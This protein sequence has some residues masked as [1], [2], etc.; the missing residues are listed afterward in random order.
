MDS[1]FRRNDG[2]AGLCIKIWYN[3]NTSEGGFSRLS[4]KICPKWRRVLYFGFMKKTFL[5]KGLVIFLGLFIATQAQA[6]IR[7]NLPEVGWVD[8]T[9]VNPFV[10]INSTALTHQYG[11]FTEYTVN[12]KTYP[13][14]DWSQLFATYGKNEGEW[15]TLAGKF[16]VSVQV[17]PKKIVVEKFGTNASSF[18]SVPL[19]RKTWENNC[20]ALKLGADTIPKASSMTMELD[21]T[22]NADNTYSTTGIKYNG[23]KINYSDGF[24]GTSEGLTYYN[25]NDTAHTY[26]K[27]NVYIFTI[28]AFENKM[29]FIPKTAGNNSMGNFDIPKGYPIDSN[30]YSS[31]IQ[32]VVTPS[33]GGDVARMNE[34]KVD[35]GD[36]RLRLG[37]GLPPYLGFTETDKRS[38]GDHYVSANQTTKGKYT[39]AGQRIFGMFLNGI[40]GDNE[41]FGLIYRVENGMKVFKK[42]SDIN[43]NPA[44]CLPQNLPPKEI[45]DF[46]GANSVTQKAGYSYQS[47]GANLLWAYDDASQDNLDN[48]LPVWFFDR[49]LGDS[50]SDLGD[51]SSG[52]DLALSIGGPVV[53]QD[54]SFQVTK[55]WAQEQGFY[56]Y[57]H[58]FIKKSAGNY[59]VDQQALPKY[60]KDRV[61]KLT[62]SNKATKK[63]KDYI[64]WPLNIE[65]E[66]KTAN[67]THGLW[68]DTSHINLMWDAFQEINNYQGPNDMN[69]GAAF[70]A[71]NSWTN[72]AANQIANAATL[73]ANNIAPPSY[74]Y[75]IQTH[76]ATALSRRVGL[77]YASA[78][79][80][81]TRLVFQIY[82][83]P[84]SAAKYCYGLGSP[85][86][87]PPTYNNWPSLI[88]SVLAQGEAGLAAA[89][90]AKRFSGN[91]VSV[92]IS[93]TAVSFDVDANISSYTAAAANQIKNDKG[94]LV[95]GLVAGGGNAVMQVKVP[96]LS[97]AGTACSFM[98]MYGGAESN[99]SFE[100]ILTPLATQLHVPRPTALIKDNQGRIF[101]QNLEVA[102]GD[103]TFLLA[104]PY[105]DPTWE[106]LKASPKNPG[107]VGVLKRALTMNGWTAAVGTDQIGF[108][109]A[110]PAEYAYRIGGIPQHYQ[111]VDASSYDNGSAGWIFYEIV[112]NGTSTGVKV[113]ALKDNSGNRFEAIVVNNV[114]ASDTV[115]LY[116]AYMN[117]EGFLSDVFKKSA[118]LASADFR[119]EGVRPALRMTDVNV[120]QIEGGQYNLTSPKINP[121]PIPTQYTHKAV[122]YSA[123][124]TDFCEGTGATATDPILKWFYN[125][126]LGFKGSSA[127]SS[128]WVEARKKTGASWTAL[129]NFEVSGTAACVRLGDKG[130][131]LDLN[132]MA[133]AVRVVDSS[134]LTSDWAVVGEDNAAVSKFWNETSGGASGSLPAS[135]P[136]SGSSSNLSQ[137]QTLP[138]TT[139]SQLN[140]SA[141]N[142]TAPGTAV[143]GQAYRPVGLFVD[144]KALYYQRLTQPAGTT[145]KG[146]IL[147][148]PRVNPNYYPLTEVTYNQADD[149]NNG[150][151]AVIV[152]DGAV[153]DA[154]IPATCN[155]SVATK[156]RPIVLTYTNGQPGFQIIPNTD[157]A[158]MGYEFY[159]E[160]QQ[161]GTRNWLKIPGT[162]TEPPQLSSGAT[163]PLT[164]TNPEQ[165]IA[166][167]TACYQPSHDLIDG[168][169]R[170]TVKAVSSEKNTASPMAAKRTEYL[171]SD[172]FA[173]EFS[174]VA[175]AVAGGWGAGTDATSGT[176]ALFIRPAGA[177]LEPLPACLSATPPCRMPVP[178]SRAV[179]FQDLN[180]ASGKLSIIPAKKNPSVKAW[181]LWTETNEQESVKIQ[182]TGECRGQVASDSQP[183]ATVA[184][185]ATG[186][187][188]LAGGNILG[189]EWAL[190]ILTGSNYILANNAT[191]NMAQ[192]TTESCYVPVKSLPKGQYRV[193]V[194]GVLD[195]RDP[196]NLAQYLKSD[197]FAQSFDV[198]GSSTIIPAS[199]T[200]STNGTTSVNGGAGAVNNPPATFITP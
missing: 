12:G 193:E 28:I 70:V 178:A 53:F 75:K 114:S 105:G 153:V 54:A 33:M 63:T 11:A 122:F 69:L 183:L 82:D 139:Q 118:T 68:N 152:N 199:A 137:Y 41:D 43:A 172:R 133:F 86:N 15:N 115:D 24:W 14:I 5:I 131:G 194:K 35:R 169:Y 123:S 174:V 17:C 2:R 161:P 136:A 196:V 88:N 104:D 64:L 159:L 87:N 36:I 97:Q 157:G 106:S 80:T 149:I 92:P 150:Q 175:Q 8:A 27:K 1:G 91:G 184:S 56:I 62:V 44:G 130:L 127:L 166:G 50:S 167:A 135:A 42:C 187:K 26:S 156:T 89:G 190:K 61:Y 107:A 40:H 121:N 3:L 18:S 165:F 47:A 10:V 147:K 117:K 146:L 45:E 160:R 37:G 19:L 180:Q 6:T 126:A 38:T 119:D 100:G 59:E 140:F 22:K 189:Y 46:F 110:R 163:T 48:V 94:D 132:E 29:N 81:P 144:G 79:Q 31:S 71:S 179:V 142:Q 9:S 84:K 73:S 93:Y 198:S 116:I 197:I 141:Q 176:G 192:F 138:S 195:Q 101:R 77:P 113:Q 155:G 108:A 32:L 21:L 74:S 96:S 168:N 158:I 128:Y 182:T 143:S 162:G 13:K 57:N 102:T 103:E 120:Y 65:G 51:S 173:Y 49:D 112:K 164:L 185:P 191:S 109:W 151:R 20:V 23:K 99:V 67:Q 145:K 111:F 124:D 30:V 177:F 72:G 129:K 83:V 52:Y 90:I 4:R 154:N 55:A 7:M 60:E 134:S 78:T 170:I 16:T 34:L 76:W 25:A 188:A 39:A 95:G 66:I 148:S 181:P 186:F 85:L 98:A 125:S 58:L 200:S 171:K